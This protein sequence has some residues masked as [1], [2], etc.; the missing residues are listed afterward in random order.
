ML[1]YANG[2]LAARSTLVAGL[3]SCADEPF[4]AR[5]HDFLAGLSSDELQ[6]IAEFIGASIL[7]SDKRCPC[8]R[9]QMAHRIT[10]FRQARCAGSAGC[11]D[12][13]H[14]MILLLEFLCGSSLR[15][16]TLPPGARQTTQ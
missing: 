8:S 3:L 11:S 1:P 4:R 12:E 15:Q 9:E 7:E 6:F 16:F 14:K 10:A 13:E 2:V 5:I